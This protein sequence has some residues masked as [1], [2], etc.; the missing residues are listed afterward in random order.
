[1][2]KDP[3]EISNKLNPAKL[4]PTHRIFRDSFINPALVRKNSSTELKLPEDL[5]VRRE[6]MNINKNKTN[7]NVVN[8]I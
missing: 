7:A 8:N 1:M 5:A 6:P 4:K 2:Q 3:K